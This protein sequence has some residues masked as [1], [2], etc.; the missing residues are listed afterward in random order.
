M[1]IDGFKTGSC[2]C[3]GHFRL[4]VDSLFTQNRNTRTS[5]GGNERSRNIFFGIKCCAYKKS[6]IIFHRA[7]GVFLIRAGRIVTHAGNLPRHFRPCFLQFATRLFKEFFSVGMDFQG[8]S[9]RH[10]TNKVRAVCQVCIFNRRMN[11]IDAVSTDLKHRSQFFIKER[12]NNV[13]NLRSLSHRGQI[14]SNTR[15]TGKHHF[16]SRSE[17]TTVSSIVISQYATGQR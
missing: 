6:R 13:F 17:Q 3:S 7:A 9:I 16:S 12:R 15:M 14:K 11:L 5:T 10:F 8:I 2:K 1:N 4:T